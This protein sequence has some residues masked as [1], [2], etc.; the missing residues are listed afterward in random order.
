MFDDFY[1]NISQVEN[2]DLESILDVPFV[3]TDDRLVRQ[4]IELAGVN[5][6][7]LVY[8]LGC[9]DGRIV[10]TAARDYGARGV[11][12]DKD[13]ERLE[14]A[15][16]LAKWN[17]VRHMLAL[18]EEDLLLVDISKATVVMLYLLPALNLELRPKL[19]NDLEPGAR[20][21]SHDFDM[22][23]WQPDK[24]V[25]YDDG[26]L[27]LWIVPAKVAGTW[28]WRESDDRV[29]RVVLEQEF[30]RV[31]GEAWI[32]DQPA[33]IHSVHLR[34]KHLKFVIQADEAAPPQEF[35]CRYEND[36]LV[37]KAGSGQVS[38]GRRVA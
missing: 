19:L 21:V 11:G 34:G 29:Y 7:D 22:A 15:R 5:E 36:R 18:I 16:D 37:P 10:V 3:P 23:D 35:A 6:K 20:I 24:R 1:Q 27:L 4:M 38:V 13:P 28:E 2:A 17:G 31:S 9:G 33:Q 26:T 8:D 14:E 30:Q 12:I 32:N 25:V